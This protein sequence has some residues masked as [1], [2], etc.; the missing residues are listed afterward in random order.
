MSKRVFTLLLTLVMCLALC[1]VTA[2]GAGSSISLDKSVYSPSDTIIVTVTGITPEMVENYAYVS[3][4]EKDAP[5]TEYMSWS[6]PTAGDC[7]L[8]FVAPAEPGLYEMRLYKEDY[9]FTDEVFVMSVPFTVSMQKRGKI[10]LEKSAYQARQLISVT[11]TD[12]TAEMEVAGAFVSIYKKGAKH[13]E[14]GTYQFVKAGNSVV[15]LTAPNLNGEF[16]MRLYSINHNYTD[17]SFVMSIPFTLSG[18]VESKASQWA[19]TTI[20]KA[21]ELGLIPDTLK[22]VHMTK[23]ITRKEFELYA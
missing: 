23:P 3:I 1:P 12:I 10:S 19:G 21:E 11:V 16:E 22:G 15:E 4:Y 6:R 14:W 20:E 13:D 18:A 9:V 8:E 5:H 2:L 17:E 7:Q